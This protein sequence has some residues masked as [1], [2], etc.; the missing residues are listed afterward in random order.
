M[1]KERVE[2]PKGRQSTFIK[3]TKELSGKTWRGLEK[4]T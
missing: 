2:F 4:F 1:R 3:E